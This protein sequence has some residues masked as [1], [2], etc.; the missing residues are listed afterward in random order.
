[1]TLST[2]NNF[3]RLHFHPPPSPFG[4]HSPPQPTKN[5]IVR[6]C[7]KTS[8]ARGGS[9][10]HVKEGG[11][12]LGFGVWGLGCRV[13]CGVQGVGCRVGHARIWPNRIWPKPHLAKTAFFGQKIRIW[14]GH[15]RDRI[16]PEL[17]F[18][19]VDRI[20]PNR[21]WPELVFSVFWPCV[22]VLCVWCVLCLQDFWWVSSRFLVGVFMI[23][24][25]L[26]DVWVSSRSASPPLLPPLDGPSAG[27]PKISLFFLSPRR[28]FPRA[29]TCTFERSGASN[30][31]EI[32]RE[33]FPE[34]EERMKFPGARNFGPSNPSGP[35]HP[36][37]PPPH[38][39]RKLAKCGLA[40]FNQ[41]RLA[42]S[43]L[44]CGRDRRV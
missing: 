10:L 3:I 21:I 27:P 38:Q 25:G 14:L 42:K 24:G 13:G 44:A 35:H 41:I 23:F 31:T 30:T 33:D 19:S 17:V 28:K 43:G 7:V 26:Q 37:S 1:M 12:G 29:Q 9:G 18:Q 16:W 22:C 20:W 32:P 39:K 11:W 34:R 15:F 6:V 8:P 36:T 4:T 2:C 40:K 5:Y